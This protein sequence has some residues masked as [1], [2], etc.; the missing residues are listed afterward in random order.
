[1]FVDKLVLLGAQFD[2]M[3]LLI[4]KLSNETESKSTSVK[5]QSG[6][7]NRSKNGPKSGA[8]F[9]NVDHKLWP[10]ISQT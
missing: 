2:K 8:C 6:P 5:H 4:M 10:A 7:E 3:A 1:M 9:L